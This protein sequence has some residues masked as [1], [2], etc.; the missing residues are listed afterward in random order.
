MTTIIKA[1]D[2]DKDYSREQLLTHYVNKGATIYTIVRSISASGMTR[3]LSFKVI[4]E[5]EL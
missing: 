5:G 4:K 3:N 2:M 1:K